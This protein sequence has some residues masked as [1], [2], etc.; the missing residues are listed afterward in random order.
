[1]FWQTAKLVLEH[2]RRDVRAGKPVD[3]DDLSGRFAMDCIM[4]TMFS[5]DAGAI[6]DPERSEVLKQCQA[7]PSVYSFVLAAVTPFIMPIL[8]IGIVNK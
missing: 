5:V 6:S 4:R 7:M 3:M 2:I 1:M 8:N